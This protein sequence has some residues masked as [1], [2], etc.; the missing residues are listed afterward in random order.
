MNV[1]LPL[2]NLSTAY[3]LEKLKIQIL[4]LWEIVHD[5][6]DVYCDILVSLE[7]AVRA[8]LDS[9]RKCTTGLEEAALI[10]CIV[11]LNKKPVTQLDARR[12]REVLAAAHIPPL[13]FLG[14]D[15]QVADTPFDQLIRA[16]K[17]QVKKYGKC[18]TW[19]NM[20]L[21]ERKM[22]D[23]LIDLGELV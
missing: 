11:Q 22:A 10:Y 20:S 5:K 15:S 21:T 14:A 17:E 4:E 12:I 9:G 19:R 7:N 6:E 8:I 13:A 1:T 3:G 16:C 2:E 23:I 18:E